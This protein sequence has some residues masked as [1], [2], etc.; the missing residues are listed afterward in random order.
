MNTGINWNNESEMD[1]ANIIK[2]Y[3]GNVGILV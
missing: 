2:F 3:D 1:T